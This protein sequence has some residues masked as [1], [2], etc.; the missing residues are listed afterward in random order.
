V[1]VVLNG[2]LICRRRQINAPARRMSAAAEEILH[3]LRN[4]ISRGKHRGGSVE[5][6]IGIPS[7]RFKKG[8]VTDQNDDR[9][10]CAD[11]LQKVSGEISW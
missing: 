11:E 3:S 7:G 2:D 1:F 6:R 4:Y 9:Q 10:H 5:P 8:W